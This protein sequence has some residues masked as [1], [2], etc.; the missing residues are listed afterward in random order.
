[1]TV[2]MYR[3]LEK[4]ASNGPGNLVLVC[5]PV[6]VSFDV[7]S[8]RAARHQLDANLKGHVQG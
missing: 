7:L 6:N 8:T 4:V 3:Y 1:M 2:V 5:D